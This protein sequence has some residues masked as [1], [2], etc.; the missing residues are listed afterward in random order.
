MVSETKEDIFKQRASGKYCPIAKNPN[1]E[2][3]ASHDYWYSSL[4]FKDKTNVLIW[5]NILWI[6][7][8]KSINNVYI[9]YTLSYNG[10][11]YSCDLPP[12]SPLNIQTEGVILKN[13]KY[14]GNIFLKEEIFIPT[15]SLG[16]LF[17][18]ELNDLNSGPHTGDKSS[19]NEVTFREL[20]LRNNTSATTGYPWKPPT[21]APPPSPTPSPTPTPPQ[22]PLENQGCLS[23]NTII[24]DRYRDN[25]QKYI[26]PKDDVY[27]F[28]P[29]TNTKKITSTLYYKFNDVMSE[30]YV[31]K[32]LYFEYIVNNGFYDSE[33]IYVR[34]D[35]YGY[36]TKA[37]S[38]SKIYPYQYFGLNYKSA[39][40][41]NIFTAPSNSQFNVENLYIPY[42]FYG[43]LFPEE[44]DYFKNNQQCVFSFATITDSNIDDV[45]KYSFIDGT[46]NKYPVQTPGPTKPD[47]IP[48][49]IPDDTKPDPDDIPIPTPIPSMTPK[50]PPQISAPTPQPQQPT[51]QPQPQQTPTVTIEPTGQNINITPSQKIPFPEVLGRP[52]PNDE[53]FD[54]LGAP[55]IVFVFAFA[56][57]LWVGLYNNSLKTKSKLN[58][59]D[60][61]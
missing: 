14:A 48:Q 46:D 49:P 23:P 16:W 40:V 7:E 3:E 37:A 12:N 24:S 50:P 57:L 34:I 56:A 35:K 33:Y 43:A 47:D 22:S 17:Q 28:E 54:I 25:R 9:G 44:Y 4:V 60:V 19:T 58:I 51:P 61:R 29:L 38:K 36:I 31:Y 13:G 6:N 11:V 10:D 2:G 27:S 32:Y 1:T 53:N 20:T 52:R 15:D 21:I 18:E 42:Y 5:D 8:Y 55:T 26:K 30:I 39:N 45:D 41:T 59:Y